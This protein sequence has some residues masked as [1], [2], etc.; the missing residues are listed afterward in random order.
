MYKIRERRFRA[1]L[2]RIEV[3]VRNRLIKRV[4][5]CA[6]KLKLLKLLSLQFKAIYMDHDDIEQLRFVRSIR[7]AAGLIIMVRIECMH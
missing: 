2:S 7:L 3:Y 1:Y 5:S 6:K 4:R